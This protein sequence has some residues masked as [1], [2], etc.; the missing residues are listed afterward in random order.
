TFAFALLTVSRQ[1]FNSTDTLAPWLALAAWICWIW[2]L[3]A[4]AQETVAHDAERLLAPALASALALQLGMQSAWHGLDLHAVN[5]VI[6]ILL[7]SALTALLCATVLR[8]P[9]A[10]VRTAAR[11]SVAWLLLGPA[12]FLMSTLGGNVGRV[13]E[14]SRLSLPLAAMFIQLTLLFAVFMTGRSLP[15]SARVV[16]ITAAVAASIY[17]L[18]LRGP[19]ALLLLSVVLIVITAISTLLDRRVKW[20]AATSIAATMLLFFG[21]LFGF[22]QSYEFMPLW[23]LALVPF[24]IATALPQ[25]RVFALGQGWWLPFALSGAL[26]LLYLWPPP[27]PGS[28]DGDVLTVLSYNIHHGFN[29][30]GTPGMQGTAGQIAALNPDLIAL[31]E[32]G[33][34]WT[35]LGGN[36]VVGYLRWRFPDYETVFEPTNGQLWGNA[37]MSRLPLSVATGGAF[38]AEPGVFRYGWVQAMIHLPERHLEFYSVHLTADIEVRGGNG[39]EAQARRLI[40]RIG[41]APHVIVAGDFNAHPEDEPIQIMRAGLTDLGAEVGLGTTATWPAG[42]ANERIDYVFARGFNAIGGRIPRTTASDH[43]PL[44]VQAR[45][46][47]TTAA[48]TA[49]SNLR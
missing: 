24:A 2:L 46:S 43:L 32:I 21:L 18:L 17:T 6:P 44:W 26:T 19:A 15:A 22:Y 34:G 23:T 7:I 38:D 35:L 28:D 41:R 11:T 37:I 10:D 29:D 30:A 3:A 4:L 48:I 33:R 12:L 31:Q 20:A 49:S 36:D 47:D 14:L 1:I 42:A 25:R 5:G 9:A 40:E 27:Q 45:L 39:R 8:I 13:S 16:M